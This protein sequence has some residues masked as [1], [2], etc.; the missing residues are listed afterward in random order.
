MS[1]GCIPHGNSESLPSFWDSDIALLFIA[2][3][4]RMVWLTPCLVVVTQRMALSAPSHDW[5][6]QLSEW[7]Q[8]T[9]RHLSYWLSWLWTLCLVR[10][11]SSPGAHPF[12]EQDLVG[13]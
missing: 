2:V 1:S 12:Q 4:Q 11:F 13:I 3:V 7:N 6:S 10:L 9:L 8:Q 5:F